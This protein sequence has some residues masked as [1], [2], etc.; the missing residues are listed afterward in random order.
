M[1]HEHDQEKFRTLLRNK[2][3]RLLEER[4]DREEAWKILQEREPEAEERAQKELLS[5]SLETLEEQGTA[6]VEAIDRGLRKLETGSYGVCELCGETIPDS[7]L[8]A[9]P[10]TP[11]CMECAAEEEKE[12]A[13]STSEGEAPGDIAAMTDEDL[14]ALVWDE[15][16]NDGR[17]ETQELEVSVDHGKVTL[18][19]SLPSESKHRILLQILN[20]TLGIRNLE[21]R[22][23]IDRQLW[24]RP[25]RAPGKAE[26]PGKIEEE[27][28]L[29]GE[30]EEE[31]THAAMEEGTSTLPSDKFL[32][33]REE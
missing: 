13:V 14:E 32:P 12:P 8:E 20:D 7:R 2:R 15:L 10:W 21:D 19:G 23:S 29:Q 5:R 26:V 24:E 4:N 30:E 1:V 6:V 31:E 27:V 3:N 17:V 18:A 33:E 11:W 25:D 28:L 9:V 22:L 16:M